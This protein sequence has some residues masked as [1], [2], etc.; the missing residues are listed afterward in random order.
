LNKLL[1]SKTCEPIN[2]KKDTD[3]CEFIYKAHGW[4]KSRTLKAIRNIKEYVEVEYVGEK[5]IV[6]VYQYACYIISYDVDAVQLHEI[7]RQR[8]TSETWIEQVKG[9]AMIGV[10]LTDDFWA[11]DIL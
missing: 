4:S 6:P 9:Q 11:N 2:G 3:I 5:S 7:Y 1:E 10:T 8:S